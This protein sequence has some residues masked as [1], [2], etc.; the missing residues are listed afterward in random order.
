[1]LTFWHAFP[2]SAADTIKDAN[3]VIHEYAQRHADAVDLKLAVC[4]AVRD[5]VRLGQQF[6]YAVADR[7]ADVFTVVDHVAL[8]DHDAHAIGH[9]HV[10]ALAD[11]HGHAHAVN[12]AHAV[13][14]CVRQTH[15]KPNGNGQLNA[16]AKPVSDTEFDAERHRYAKCHA[17]AISH[18]VGN[19]LVDQ[20]WD[21]QPDGDA[22][23]DEQRD[24][25]AEPVPVPDQHCIGDLHAVSV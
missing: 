4:N 20:F 23:W 22:F 5:G 21:A 10:L 24:A 11:S 8:R 1:M 18:A 13:R 14:H 16:D 6:R 9:A 17:D 3:S 19:A 12:L 2:P 25:D 15:T 7:L